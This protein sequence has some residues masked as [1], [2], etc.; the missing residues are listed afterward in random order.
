M[1]LLHRIAAIVV[2]V[3]G[4][5]LAGCSTVVVNRAQGAATTG[6]AYAATLKQVNDLALSKSIGFGADFLAGKAPRTE[7]ALAEATEVHR[8]RIR[9]VGESSAY[10]DQLAA[11][12]T[13]LEALAK[14][15]AST[16]IGDALGGVADALKK[17]PFGVKLSD[18]RKAALTGLAKFIARQA[19]AAA[20]TKALERDADT[21]AQAIGLSD[22][23]LHTVGRWIEAQES[24]VQKEAFEQKVK[25]P[26]LGGTALGDD[27]KK[28][29]IAHVQ[30]P[31]V[32]AVL[33]SARQAS[34][35][36]QGAWQN[37]LTGQYT[38]DEVLVSLR[39]VQAG[40]DAV[41]AALHAK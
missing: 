6:K 3:L 30:G 8:D 14:G 1:L 9:T 40:I 27:W 25:K 12:F 31:P 5:G 20:V 16:E 17:E 28:A 35:S 39:N 37:L 23:M 19:H 36:L 13:G 2:T 21:V 32:V 11:Y 7:A 15:D 4:L 10:L 22:Q 29:W 24:L 26:F 38:L 34:T 18:E 33:K 41:A